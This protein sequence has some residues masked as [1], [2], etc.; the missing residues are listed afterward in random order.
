MHRERIFFVPALLMLSFASSFSQ[1]ADSLRSGYSD[2][3]RS[4]LI[5]LNTIRDPQKIEYCIPTT[6]AEAR[7]YFQFDLEKSISPAFKE[8]QKRIVRY[9]ISG[10]TKLLKQY[11]CY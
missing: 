2:S 3:V 4:I 6:K 5:H 10:N 9:S 11:L 1:P 8:L 7:R